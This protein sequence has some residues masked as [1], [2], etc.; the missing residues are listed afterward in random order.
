MK[1]HISDPLVA[2]CRCGA[3]KME[4]T[5]DPIM[6]AACYCAS[7]QA[8][9]RE[10]EGLSGAERVVHEDGGTP[11]IL[12]RKDR[13]RCLTGGDRLVERRLTPKSTTRRMLTN[14]C[15]SPM[16]LEFTKGHWLS[17]YRDRFPETAPPV[18]IRTMTADR[19]QGVELSADI[20]SY[21]THSGRFMWKLLTAWAAMGFRQ[22][23]VEGVPA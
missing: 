22:P 14:C 10:F 12:H 19:P 8:A 23:K 11:F 6:V 17:L 13:I 5:G 16:F 1:A 15:N 4:A 18:E 21:A 2:S 3:V 9:G 20:P 7:C